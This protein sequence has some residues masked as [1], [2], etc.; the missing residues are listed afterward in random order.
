MWPLAAW[1]SLCNQ[2]GC[3]ST[4]SASESDACGLLQPGWSY[5]LTRLGPGSC[6]DEVAAGGNAD[7]PGASTGVVESGERELNAATCRL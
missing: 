6:E 5:W 1:A 3:S 2:G 7:D 4:S